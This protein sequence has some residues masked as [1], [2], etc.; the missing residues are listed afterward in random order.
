MCN[1]ARIKTPIKMEQVL[2]NNGDISAYGF[3][4]GYVEK[5]K[6][7]SMYQENNIYQVVGFHKGK[8][9]NESFD[10]LKEAKNLF[11]TLSK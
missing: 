2:N 7:L 5:T 6:K 4:C 11:N 1:V 3:A 10:R 9:I 8:H